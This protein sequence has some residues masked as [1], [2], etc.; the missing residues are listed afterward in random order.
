MSK[1]NTIQHEADI[2]VVGGGMSGV[3]AAIAAARA[4]SSVALLQDRPVLGGNASEEIRMWIC[5][6]FGANLRETGIIEEIELENIFRNPHKNYAQWNALLHDVV[7]RE[8]GIELLLNASV[9][10]ATMQGTTIETVTAWQLTTQN[11]HT[12]RATLFIDC[13]G[14]SIL[15]PIT[16]AEH[17]WGREAQEEFGESHAA[18]KADGQTMGMSC[19]IQL[20]ET[21]EPQ[22]F[23]PP[24]FAHRYERDDIGPGRDL[25]IHRTNFWWLESGGRG[26]TIADTEVV[27]DDLLAVATG[28]W[29]FIKRHADEFDARNW[30][31]DWMGFLP[32][33]RESRRYVGDH[34]IT[35]SDVEAGGPFPDVIAYAGWSMDNHPPGGF[36]EPGE[37]TVF[38][39]APS[40]WGIPYRSIYSRSIDNLL[41]AGRNISATHIALSSSR[42]MRT[43]ALI[44]QAAGTAAAIAIRYRTNP[45]GVYQSHLGEL[46]HELMRADSYLPGFTRA[47]AATSSSAVLTA[48]NAGRTYTVKRARTEFP[49]DA[50]V[51]K[52]GLRGGQRTTIAWHETRATADPEVLRNGLDRTVD[53]T[54]NGYW[55]EPG[56]TIEYHL[57]EPARLSRARIV[58]DSNLSRHYKE[59]RMKYHYPLNDPGTP[60]AESL[61]RRF[62]VEVVRT[63]GSASQ[64]WETVAD[65]ADNRQRLV[66]VDLP[67][68]PV[69]GVRLTP[70][71][72]WGAKLVHLFGFEVEEG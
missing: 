36:Y 66:W 12:V 29:D 32:G 20:R 13:S 54:D 25:D 16:G 5:G 14:D 40:P 57:N 70:L 41:F 27:R 50:V 48:S 45:R 56:D 23:V 49:P 19:L 15:A 33:K 58:F 1:L 2:C 61:V 64:E 35:Q 8:P 46:Q 39:P 42:V 60:V 52:S 6:A 34:I 38:H 47:V 71:E 37:P 4:G 21:S 72:T 31:L 65:V 59:H 30:T 17:R 10:D 43:C 26:N 68:V 55:C 63:A 53:D 7:T 67:D 3:C 24:S 62:K 11:F 18:E 44:G 51:L 9:L 69:T 28:V 22:P